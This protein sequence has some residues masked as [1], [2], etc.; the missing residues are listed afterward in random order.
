M[1]KDTNRFAKTVQIKNKKASFEFEFIDTY[2]AGIMLLGS[3]IK[4][5]RE[6]KVSL[7]EAYCFLN[8]N[9][10]YIKGMNISPYKESTYTN[11]EPLR[12]RK[13][14]LNKKELE[15]L[16]TKSEEKGLTII[17]TK[18][19]INDRGLAKLS[20][21]L[22]KGKKLFD[23]RESLKTKDTERELKRLIV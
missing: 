7:Q 13:L 16:R 11:H 10:L 22:A 9:E 19:Y 5:I 18:M 12:E 8:K 1:K 17:P 20:I 4:S 15:K 2:E 6:G 21:A 3:E 14:L 23:K